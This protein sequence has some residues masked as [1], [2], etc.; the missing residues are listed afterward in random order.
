MVVFKNLFI[1]H[2][3]DV[4]LGFLFYSETTKNSRKFS[5]FLNKKFLMN[6]R[7]SSACVRQ[8]KATSYC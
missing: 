3:P 7:V 1:A 2:Y 4:V 6:L 5:K 8:S